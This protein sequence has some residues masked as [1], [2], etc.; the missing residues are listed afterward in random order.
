MQTRKEKV[1]FWHKLYIIWR[2]INLKCNYCF[3]I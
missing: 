2:K 3:I 1:T